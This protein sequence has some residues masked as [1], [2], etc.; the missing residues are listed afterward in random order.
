MGFVVNFIRF[1]AVQKY[2]YRPPYTS[3]VEA[4]SSFALT[5]R[6]RP[7]K[8]M[9]QCIML[10]DSIQLQF[11]GQSTDVQRPLSRIWACLDP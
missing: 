8:S 3:D 6:A 10:T 7:V 2:I 9:K 11:T 1:S 4:I 5:R